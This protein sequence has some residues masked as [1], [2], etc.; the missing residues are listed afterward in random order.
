MGLENC[1]RLSDYADEDV[2]CQMLDVTLKNGS[3]NLFESKIPGSVD[4]PEENNEGFVRITSSNQAS[5]QHEARFLASASSSIS[6]LII[7]HVNYAK[8]PSE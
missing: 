2:Y 6:S 5:H 3:R 4:V 1:S 7:L 8:Y